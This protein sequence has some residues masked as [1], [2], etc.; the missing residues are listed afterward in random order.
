MVIEEKKFNEIFFLRKIPKK[1]DGRVRRNEDDCPNLSRPIHQPSVWVNSTGTYADT[2]IILPTIA[3]VH[4][5]DTDVVTDS[6][7]VLHIDFLPPPVQVRA[8]EPSSR[9]SS[10]EL[11]SGNISDQRQ[12]SAKHGYMLLN[13][14]DTTAA[15]SNA[16]DTEG[17]LE[18]P[19]RRLQRG[20]RVA[21][22]GETPR[23]GQE[24]AAAHDPSLLLPEDRESKEESFREQP[25]QQ[26]A[27]GREEEDATEAP[28]AAPGHEPEPA[29]N[30]PGP[31]TPTPAES[32]RGPAAA[33]GSGP[34][35][36]PVRGR[37]A[38]TVGAPAAAAAAHTHLDDPDL[39]E[40]GE[41]D[42]VWVR[43]VQ[44]R[45]GL[46]SLDGLG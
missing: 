5:S 30:P 44:F 3:Y 35:P 40:K 11:R 17:L 37:E 31:P 6:Q 32:R 36:G 25:P 10:S 24:R 23:R 28:P 8:L 12:H 29:P 45:L 34:V 21:E 27:G 16:A 42:A 33:P 41:P 2:H 18:T 14:W 22:P 38:A 7:N 13:L 1:V 19:P 46:G 26:A 20:V 15:K 39:F 43:N 4:A 9:Q